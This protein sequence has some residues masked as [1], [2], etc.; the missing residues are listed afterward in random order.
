MCSD[1]T[2]RLPGA[3]AINALTQAEKNPDNAPARLSRIIKEQGG[4]RTDGAAIRDMMIQKK[5]F[6]VLDWPLR[7]VNSKGSTKTFQMMVNEQGWTNI[8]ERSYYGS[9]E[10][11]SSTPDTVNIISR[12]QKLENLIV[13]RRRRDM[14]ASPVSVHIWMSLYDWMCM[15]GCEWQVTTRPIIDSLSKA[16]SD[17]V[18]VCKGMVVVCV[19]R[20]VAFHGGR[21]DLGTIANKVSEIC[22]AAGALVTENDRMWRVAHALAAKNYKICGS[23]NLQH[24]R[25]KRLLV[26]KS[27]DVLAP[28]MLFIN[29]LEEICINEPDLQFNIPKNMEESKV[30]F[31]YKPTFTAQS[32]RKQERQNEGYSG[33]DAFGSVDANDLCL[34]WYTVSELSDFICE[35]CKNEMQRNKSKVLGSD[36]TFN[37][38]TCVNCCTNWNA[39][40]NGVTRSTNGR[41]LYTR[42]FAE[43]KVAIPGLQHLM[44]DVNNVQAMTTIIRELAYSKLKKELSHVGFVSMTV[45]QAAQYYGYKYGK[46]LCATRDVVMCRNPEGVE[47]KTSIFVIDKD[48]DNVAYSSWI[49]SVNSWDKLPMK[50]LWGT[51]LK[52]CWDSSK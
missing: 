7:A 45:D 27:I 8:E 13:E 38:S 2:G 29:E 37:P 51:S 33:Q 31:E 30:R 9:S 40:T 1:R 24:Y 32:R 49:K 36:T 10:P 23:S 39:C 41:K 22:K 43:C 28:S 19:N 5:S 47:E 44:A 50:S 48:L 3:K 16:I 4:R 35:L 42:L 25:L 18:N 12:L 14:D 15:R 26:E 52:W 46:Q 17:L 11:A 6:L 34:R 20:D 21:G